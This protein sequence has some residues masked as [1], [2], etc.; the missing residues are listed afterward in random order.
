AWSGTQ[1]SLV[2]V[3][4]DTSVTGY[5]VSRMSSIALTTFTPIDGDGDEFEYVV[6]EFSGGEYYTVSGFSMDSDSVLY[7]RYAYNY[8][9]TGLGND[10]EKI[11]LVIFAR[12]V[13]SGDPTGDAVGGGTQNVNLTVTG[14]LGSG[15]I[16]TSF[17]LS[18]ADVDESSTVD[19]GTMIG[20][21]NNNGVYD[22]TFANVNYTNDDTNPIKI[23]S[24]SDLENSFISFTD[25]DG[26]QNQHHWY[27]IADDANDGTGYIVFDVDGDGAGNDQIHIF[28]DGN[29]NWGAPTEGDG[30]FETPADLANDGGLTHQQF[31]DL[32][33]NPTINSDNFV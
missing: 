22:I 2:T 26:N 17:V 4:E 16:T 1:P 27:F 23:D 13:T 5:S 3:N 7:S 30:I 28:G 21:N 12:G 15:W 25:A 33:G 24:A 32:L 18:I 10:N 29:W 20:V 19:G 8:E 31:L 9:A 14:N 11:S 6:L